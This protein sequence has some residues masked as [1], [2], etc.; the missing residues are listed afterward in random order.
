M[1]HTGETPI[2]SSSG[3][4]VIPATP[5]GITASGGKITT[6][7]DGAA[8]LVLGA[9]AEV[10][11]ARLGLESEVKV[12][13]AGEK[14]HSLEM[15]KGQLFLNISAEQLKQ[16]GNSE[17]KLKTPTALLAVKGT[18]FFSSTQNGTDTIGVHE[19]SV[20]VVE[21][22]TGQKTTV[23]A[24]HAV[25]VS[26]GILN[27]MR[28]MT[29][30]EKKF[31]PEYDKANISRM[32]CGIYTDSPRLYYY[33]GLPVDAKDLPRRMV[34]TKGVLVPATNRPPDLVEDHRPWLNWKEA[35]GETQEGSLFAPKPQITEQ[36]TVRYVWK[37]RLMRGSNQAEPARLSCTSYAAFSERYG[38]GNQ[39]IWRVWQRLVAVA[40][41]IRTIRVDLVEMAFGRSMIYNAKP[42]SKDRLTNMQ[43]PTD[44]SWLSVT[45]PVRDVIVKN[46]SSLYP[47]I[48]FVVQPHLPEKLSQDSTA[49]E[50]RDFVLLFQP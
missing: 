6:G 45:L 19:G 22:T 40:F 44:G 16:R 18:K 32:S 30:E 25:D 49:I 29:E 46:D 39:E 8:S 5:A 37:A 12:P 14:G 3:N 38:Y 7:A 9:G 11:T 24:G 27:A 1:V 26:P 23:A 43:L 34:L 28:E 36:G 35:H 15:L 48:S 20:E 13:D 17:F 4:A 50:L 10:G 21:P 47:S 31:V 33:Q 42:S 41:Q 2:S